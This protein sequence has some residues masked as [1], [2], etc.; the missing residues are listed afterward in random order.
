MSLLMEYIVVVVYTAV[1]ATTPL[2]NDY[3]PNGTRNPSEEYPMR[4]AQQVYVEPQSQIGY[5]PVGQTGYW[6]P[7]VA[8]M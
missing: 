8:E 7:R 2:Q 1:G 6:P 5:A 4:R 3:Y